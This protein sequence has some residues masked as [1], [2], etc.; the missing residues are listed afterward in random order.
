[1]FI[2]VAQM[3]PNIAPEILIHTQ[4]LPSISLSNVA[5]ILTTCP[6]STTG[7]TT[8]QLLLSLVWRNKAERD[9]IA[10]PG[11]REGRKQGQGK[12]ASGSRHCLTRHPSS[13]VLLPRHGAA[14]LTEGKMAAILQLSQY[15]TFRMDSISTV[16]TEPGQPVSHCVGRQHPFRVA[17]GLP[18]KAPQ[19]VKD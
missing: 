19:E 2:K 17:A 10:F 14:L 11:S 16:I 8:S 6:I 7:Q 5:Q 3:S 15:C 1:M 4:H 12:R 13:S 9:G 18:R